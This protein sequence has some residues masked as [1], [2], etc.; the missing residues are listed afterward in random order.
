MGLVLVPDIRY[1]VLLVPPLFSLMLLLVWYVPVWFHTFV[2]VGL[3][4]YIGVLYLGYIA[5][6]PVLHRRMVFLVRPLLDMIAPPPASC[7]EAGPRIRA[8]VI[9]FLA[10]ARRHGRMRK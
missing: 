6:M 10:E 4:V 1:Q 8:E 7:H 9:S 5:V 3:A 2:I